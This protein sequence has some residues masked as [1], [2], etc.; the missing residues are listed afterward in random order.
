MDRA[1]LC[2]HGRALNMGSKSRDEVTALLTAKS[3]LVLISE[4]ARRKEGQRMNKLHMNAYDSYCDDITGHEN[5]TKRKAMHIFS[6]IK[7]LE[8][9]QVSTK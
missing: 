9:H 7:G 2:I 1:P 6:S 3:K 4:A 8:R 5:P